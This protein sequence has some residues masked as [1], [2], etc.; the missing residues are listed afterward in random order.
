M[1]GLCSLTVHLMMPKDLSPPSEGSVIIRSLYLGP[2]GCPHQ[3][4][5]LSLSGRPSSCSRYSS[6][7]CARTLLRSS[8][9][10]LR[11]TIHPPFAFLVGSGCF[12]FLKLF[13]GLD[14][15]VLGSHFHASPFVLC[16]V[17]L[18][19]LEHQCY[20]LSPFAG[21]DTVRMCPFYSAYLCAGLGLY[22]I[23]S[24][25]SSASFP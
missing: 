6:H 15:V 22:T 8:P 25:G 18:P 2:P 12:P 5:S 13:K 24:S 9:S 20:G 11:I 17:Y 3:P 23:L 19:H 1:V 16:D 21:S 10:V 4:L 14:D 7:T